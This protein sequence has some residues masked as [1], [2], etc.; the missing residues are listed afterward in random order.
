LEE[1]KEIRQQE[2]HKAASPDAQAAKSHAP[3]AKHEAN[4]GVVLDFK[5]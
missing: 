2:N 3:Q 5:I 1:Q 4:P